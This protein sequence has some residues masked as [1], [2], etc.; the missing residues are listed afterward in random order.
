MKSSGWVIPF[1]NEWRWVE[2]VNSG[3]NGIR[4]AWQSF[5]PSAFSV[6]GRSSTREDPPLRPTCPYY[7]FLLLPPS[8]QFF[9][10]AIQRIARFFRRDHFRSWC[11]SKMLCR[12]QDFSI[13]WDF[14][15]EIERER[16]KERE[17][18]IGMNIFFLFFLFNNFVYP[19]SFLLQLLMMFLF[20]DRK[21]FSWDW[22]FSQFYF[23]F[24]R[25]SDFEKFLFFLFLQRILSISTKVSRDKSVTTELFFPMESYFFFPFPFSFSFISTLSDDLSNSRVINALAVFRSLLFSKHVFHEVSVYFIFR[26]R[27]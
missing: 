25:E 20:C 7:V 3:R 27:A 24:E 9:L 12:L 16:E 14:F 17:R 1:V 5:E 19:F 22:F 10:P 23:S 15:E 11:S 21:R 8:P 6:P 26:I 13:L 4:G 18:E 2:S